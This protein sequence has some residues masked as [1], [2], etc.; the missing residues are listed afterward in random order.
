MLRR[1]RRDQRGGAAVEFGLIAP[2]LAI[3]VVGI[4]MTATKLTAQNRIR[5][6]V[7]TGAQ[8]AMTNSPNAAQVQAV[9]LAAWS[10]K[11]GDASVT[12]AQSC[13]CPGVNNH[14]CN[15]ICSNGDYPAM[16][17]RIDATGTF[18]GETIS[19]SQTVR[20]R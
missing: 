5:Q 20:T 19:A 7:S 14:A 1:F 17:T 13:S 3:V 15:V 2:L 4:G 18:D 12:V 9:T 10:G 16:S 11:P 8:Y 6:A